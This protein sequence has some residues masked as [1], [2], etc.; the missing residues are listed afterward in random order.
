MIPNTVAFV[1]APNSSNGY[2]FLI[3]DHPLPKPGSPDFV[4]M[5]TNKD[6]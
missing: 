1:W 6:G 5:D 2:P 4:L 3:P